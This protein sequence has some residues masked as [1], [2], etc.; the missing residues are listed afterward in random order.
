MVVLKS[1]IERGN[2]HSKKKSRFERNGKRGS[3]HKIWAFLRLWNCIV[4][5]GFRGSEANASSD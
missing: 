2:I 1:G 5:R 3:P 4:F